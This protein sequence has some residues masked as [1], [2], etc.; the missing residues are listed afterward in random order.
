MNMTTQVLVD[1]RYKNVWHELSFDLDE[2]FDA[3]NDGFV[4]NKFAPYALA[5]A[6]ICI[7]EK[8]FEQT[9]LISKYL[10]HSWVF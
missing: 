5:L 7:I 10:L 4:L 3:L 8:W 1:L 2:L 9:N 6:P